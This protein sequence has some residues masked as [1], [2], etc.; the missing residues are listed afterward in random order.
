MLKLGGLWAGLKPANDVQH[1]SGLS[2]GSDQPNT[3]MSDQVV[4]LPV[5][6]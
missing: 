5:V 6:R 1:Q 4:T 3:Q 2:Q